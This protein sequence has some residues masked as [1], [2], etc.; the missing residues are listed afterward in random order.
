[1]SKFPPVATFEGSPVAKAIAAIELCSDAEAAVALEAVAKAKPTADEY[2]RYHKAALKIGGQGRGRP[3]LFDNKRWLDEMEFLLKNEEV[4]S[5][6][7]AAIKV[8]NTMTD[9]HEACDAV[10]RLSVNYAR[11]G[12]FRPRPRKKFSNKMAI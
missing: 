6:N 1:L 2:K 5:I 9:P 7:A 10:T 3:H 11:E 8:V 12:R 4:W